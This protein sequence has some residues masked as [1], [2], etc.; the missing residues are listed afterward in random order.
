[1]KK[2]V[3]KILAFMAAISIF[4]GC[5]VK[6]KKTEVVPA[7]PIPIA[8]THKAPPE[9]VV[10][11]QKP[12]NQTKEEVKHKDFVPPQ[13]AD[14][15]LE[16]RRLT[17]SPFYFVRSELP[18][19]LQQSIDGISFSDFSLDMTKP[20]MIEDI[21]NLFVLANKANYYPEDFK[22]DQLVV[23]NIPFSF[24]GENEKKYLQKPAADALTDLI[25]AAKKDNIAISGVSG[26]RSIARQKV[27]YKYNIDTYGQAHA[28]QYSARPQF[29]EHHTGLCMDVSSKSVGFDLVE[30]YGSTKEGIWLAENAH[31]FGFII[32]YPKG[33]EEIT[34]YSYEPWHI[35]YLGVPLASFLYQ[36]QLCYEEFVMGMQASEGQTEFEVDAKMVPNDAQLPPK[37]S[38]N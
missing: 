25:E 21:R 20:R 2:R 26:Y 12:E 17:D 4:N 11:S 1:M 8:E 36:N 29:S 34:G 19:D 13:T 10:P 27:L 6:D 31:R 30:Q 24:A 23:P 14:N 28:N 7:N 18:E 22:P 15:D 5:A 38:V 37:K 32:R 9:P 35:R 3:I 16:Q 33:K